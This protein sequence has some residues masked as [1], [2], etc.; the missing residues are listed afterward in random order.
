MI[1]VFVWVLF[2]AVLLLMWIVDELIDRVRDLEL[3]LSQMTII[4][5]IERDDV[6]ADDAR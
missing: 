2:F 1:E 4:E 3:R 5:I 6:G